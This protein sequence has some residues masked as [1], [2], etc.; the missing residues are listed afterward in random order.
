M[1]S[2]TIKRQKCVLAYSYM[3]TERTTA[4]ISRFLSKKADFFLSYEHVK[5][6]QGNSVNYYYSEAGR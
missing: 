1:R 2:G 3:R 5:I 4:G 6:N